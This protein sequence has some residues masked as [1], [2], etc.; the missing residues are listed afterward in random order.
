MPDAADI[1]V[2]GRNGRLVLPSGLGAAETHSHT[3]A[4][5]GMVTASELVR[6]A[7]KVGLSVL[8]ITDHDVMS[9]ELDEAVELGAELG[10]DVVRGEEVTCTFPPGTHVIGLFLTRPI[11]MHMS[12]LDT[13][14]A[15]HDEGGLAI[16]AHP[17][18]PTWFASMTP[19]QMRDL[20]ERRTVDGVE[21]RHTDRKSTRLNSSHYSRSRMPSSA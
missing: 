9:G 10:V 2:A 19:G 8:C 3:R 7:A 18:M 13:V 15:I 6:A 12:V 5:D 16:I 21:L 11:R 14:D 1:T 4:S 20:L 17:F